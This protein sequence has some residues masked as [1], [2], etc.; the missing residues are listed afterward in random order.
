MLQHKSLVLLFYLFV[1]RDCFAK[2]YCLITNF[3][4]SYAYWRVNSIH[5]KLQQ[6]MRQNSPFVNDKKGKYPQKLVMTQS[7]FCFVDISV[8]S[9][10]E[11]YHF[12]P[13]LI[14]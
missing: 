13:V 11:T 10:Y 6:S 9:V 3:M 8:Y 14:V 4:G 1:D 12:L 2:F 5:K 7:L